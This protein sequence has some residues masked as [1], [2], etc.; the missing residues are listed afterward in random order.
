MTVEAHKYKK[1]EYVMLKVP[2]RIEQ[3]EKRLSPDKEQQLVVRMH[4]DG[5]IGSTRQLERLLGQTA[6]WRFESSSRHYS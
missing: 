3:V 2:L 1:G 5:E 6:P 4:R